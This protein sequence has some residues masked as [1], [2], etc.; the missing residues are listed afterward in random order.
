M[1]QLPE[2]G[3]DAVYRLTARGSGLDGLAGFRY[4]GERLGIERNRSIVPCHGH[5]ISYRE[6]MAIQR[7]GLRHGDKS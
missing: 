6:R 4:G 7:D 1:G 2:T 5:D 3:I